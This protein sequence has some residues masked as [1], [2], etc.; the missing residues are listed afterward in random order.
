M[1]S[2]DF[3]GALPPLRRVFRMDSAKIGDDPICRACDALGSMIA[4]Y[5]L[6]DSMWAAEREA[7]RWVALQRG[8]ARAWRSLATT[9]EYQDR[10]EEALAARSLA[11][12]LGSENPR[13]AVYGAVLALRIGDFRRAD[14][15]LA[16]LEGVT[17]PLVRQNVLWYRTL[18]SRYQGRFDAALES[19]VRYRDIVASAAVAGHPPLWAPVLQAQVLEEMGKAREAAA[20]WRQIASPPYEPDSPSRSARHRAWTLTQAAAAYAAAGDTAVLAGLADT[21]QALG[22]QSSYGR[23]PRLH[24]FVR[25]L[26]LAAR[27]DTA[28]AAAA[29]RR[30]V[31]SLTQG[32]GRIN[33][34]LGRA[35]LALGR[36]AEAI[37]VLRGV[38]SG[39]L[40]AGNLYVNRRDVH[41]LLT[42]AYLS[43]GSPDSAQINADWVRRALGR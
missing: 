1:S 33:L 39:P 13:D 42:R 41:A 2:G 15:L 14:Q 43:A 17:D 3:L 38:L 5:L 20:L 11:A 32:Y 10:T 24:H 27:G 9:L 40:D 18:S 34:E 37:P 21:I 31:F 25:G 28:S 35:L 29:Y 8:S 30:A 26:L 36:P 12:S 4:A 19:A 23:D 16:E 6:A 22:S 7:R